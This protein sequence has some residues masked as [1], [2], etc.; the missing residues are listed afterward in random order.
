MW[1]QE[2]KIYHNGN[3][4]CSCKNQE[5]ANLYVELKISKRALSELRSLIDIEEEMDKMMSLMNLLQR[6]N[7]KQTFTPNTL[8]IKN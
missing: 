7:I 1:F 3:Q 2:R 6:Q 4:P 8:S 5:C